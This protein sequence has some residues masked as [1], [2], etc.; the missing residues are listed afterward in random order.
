MS[1]NVLI[2]AGDAV[3][4]LEIYYPYYRLLEEGYQVTIAAPKKK[5]LHTVVHDFANWDTYVEKQGYLIEAQAAFA[6]IDPNDYDGL[7]IP[8]GRAPEYIRLDADL[9]RIVRHFFEANKPIAAIC[10]ASLIF[11]TMPDV[12]KG[13]SLTAYIACK[14]GME[15]L[16]ATYVS[17]RTI[18]VDQNLVSAHAWP[19]LP[20]FMRE[21]I[22]LLQ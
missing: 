9:Q 22:R 20:I 18:H 7:V 16:G 14:P 12:V 19:D 13:R 5:K 3:E 4:A 10:H 1:K 21:F 15:A 2:V 11:E 6:D 17:D 8:G